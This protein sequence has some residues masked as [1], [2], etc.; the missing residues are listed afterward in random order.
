VHQR[1]AHLID[2]FCGHHHIPSLLV[3][4]TIRNAAPSV[5]SGRFLHYTI[6]VLGCPSIVAIK[7]NV[8]YR[9]IESTGGAHLHPLSPRALSTQQSAQIRWVYLHLSGQPFLAPAL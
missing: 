1:R 2:F 5:G 8:G 9:Y 3:I 6:V 7:Q 4:V